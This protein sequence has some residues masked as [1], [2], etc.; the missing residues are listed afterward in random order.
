MNKLLRSLSLLLCACT[1]LY[2]FAQHEVKFGYCNDELS[3][4]YEYVANENPQEFT[5]GCAILIPSSRLQMLKGQKI[6][7]MRFACTEGITSCN[8]WVK[9]QL[10]AMPIAK[11]YKV[12]TTVGGWNEVTFAEPI[13]IT[14]DDLYIGYSGKVPY[15]GAIFFDGQVNP[16]GVFMLEN[17]EWSDWSTDGC[18]PLCIQAFATIDSDVPLVDLGIEKVS[19]NTPYTQKGNDVQASVQ[20]GNYGETA[21]NAPKLFYSVNGAA[22]V[23]ITTS[24]SI[25]TNGSATYSFNVPTT[26]LEEGKI[27]LRVWAET[28]DNYKGNDTLSTEMLVYTNSYPHKVLCEHFTT[29]EC[30]NCP[31]GHDALKALFKNKYNY[32]W[33]GHHIGYLT[34]ELTQQASY[35]LEKFGATQAPLAMFDRRVL[36]GSSSSTKPVIGINWGTVSASVNAISPSFE[37]CATTP[38]FVSVNIKNSYNAETRELTTTVSGE[39]NKL[40]PIFYDQSMLTV[41]L[42]EDSV[43]TQAGQNNTN[44]RI[45]SNVFRQAITRTLGDEMLWNGDNYSETYTVSI[46]EDYNPK[47]LRVVAFVSLPTT[48]TSHADVL[49]ANEL[50][51]NLDETTGINTVTTDGA[52]VLSRSFYNM[53]GQR[54]NRP[55]V[56]GAYLERIETTQ[57]VQTVKRIK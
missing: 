54:I 14:G 46:P 11:V 23:A 9:N 24:G 1:A 35:D 51:I 50:N 33:V 31:I 15:G 17:G 36:N 49:N 8:A 12:G 52:Q 40:F 55:T 6:T 30:V 27:P 48:D 38:A 56:N 32:V 25:A 28:D 39:R 41:E 20:V 13:V 4:R 45:H 29:L 21:I 16:N 43:K 47:N 26:A 57:G 7:R 10:N 44:E 53:Q 37:A 22:P 42:V 5:F 34:D 19:F 2:T 3:P 18:R